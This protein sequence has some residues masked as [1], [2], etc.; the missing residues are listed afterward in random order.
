MPI[1]Y[2]V[3]DFIPVVGWPHKDIKSGCYFDRNT[4]N[5]ST[6]NYDTYE[7]DTEGV[8]QDSSVPRTSEHN[9]HV[10]HLMM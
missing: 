3:L 4:L 5:Q 6:L 7:G 10:C 9:F 2:T 1:F 8:V